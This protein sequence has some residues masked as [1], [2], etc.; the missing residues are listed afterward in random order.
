MA[1]VS[2]QRAWDGYNKLAFFK[3]DTISS[4]VTAVGYLTKDTLCT[5]SFYAY[6]Y[7]TEYNSIYEFDSSSCTMSNSTSSG[8]YHFD[9]ELDPV[10]I[11]LVL[12]VFLLISEICSF[13]I[14]WRFANEAHS[15]H[16]CNHFID[17]E[18]SRVVREYFGLTTFEDGHQEQYNRALRTLR[19]FDLTLNVLPS[20]VVNFVVFYYADGWFYQPITSI[21]V[22]FSLMKGFDILWEVL[23][24]HST[25]EKLISWTVLK[26]LPTSVNRWFGRCLTLTSLLTR[27][28]WVWIAMYLESYWAYSTL[29]SG[30]DEVI[31]FWCMIAVF[32]LIF[33]AMALIYN[34]AKAWEMFPETKIRGFLACILWNADTVWLANK[35]GD[36]YD[37]LCSFR[38]SQTNALLYAYTFFAMTETLGLDYSNRLDVSQDITFPTVLICWTCFTGVN[39]LLE[40]IV[41]HS[42]QHW[43]ERENGSLVSQESEM[44]SKGSDSQSGGSANP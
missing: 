34:I 35:P 7:N 44:G 38:V 27:I 1:L 17:W 28:G 5:E 41:R 10:A 40:F 23:F 12:L 9:T 15:G 26:G 39:M 8:T 37:T 29:G 4:F 43:L 13:I 42:H 3:T 30:S 19:A 33:T 14:R 22:M 32:G 20:L 31:A 6:K 24:R 2:V 36:K 11:G 18:D 21:S 16:V 25:G